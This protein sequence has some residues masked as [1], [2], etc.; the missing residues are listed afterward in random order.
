VLNG[1]SEAA[2][3]LDKSVNKD[4]ADVAQKAGVTAIADLGAKTQT[5]AF[6]DQVEAIV[7]IR[8]YYGGWDKYVALKSPDMP[9]DEQKKIADMLTNRTILMVAL[10][11]GIQQDEAAK[12]TV[13]SSSTVAPKTQTTTAPLQAPP[14]DT[15]GKWRT[16]NPNNVGGYF[17]KGT[18]IAQ[19]YQTLAAK[20]GQW[21]PIADFEQKHA[22]GPNILNRIQEMKYTGQRSGRWTVEKSG[23]SVRIFLAK[24]GDVKQTVLT[25]KQVATAKDLVDK[26]QAL[27][28]DQALS[29]VITDKMKTAFAQ[30]YTAMGVSSQSQILMEKAIKDWTYS[31]HGTE[32]Q[33]MRQVAMQ[34]YNRK[35][36]GEYTDGVTNNIKDGTAGSKAEA[37]KDGV[38][39]MKAYAS[40]YARQAGVNVVYRGLSGKVAQSIKDAI[41]GGATKVNIPMNALSS[42]SEKKG[43]AQ[44]FSKDYSGGVIVKMKIDPDNVW[45]VHAATPWLFSAHSNE[46]EYIVGA[47]QARE[48][49]D[50]KDITVK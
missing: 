13:P 50:V 11:K 10:S 20:E 19:M 39:A 12:A 47:K 21:H 2:K 35:A 6:K 46:A 41:A 38:M 28:A 3:F 42:W 32:A 27:K 24:A 36:E 33:G 25:D 34:F 26:V 29:G 48:T 5:V 4:Y 18:T 31:A 44:S 23:D 17:R 40:E 9:Q 30:Y 43:T 7:A 37:M 45:A 1:I 15:G 16:Y 49:F 14:P 8:N 22:G